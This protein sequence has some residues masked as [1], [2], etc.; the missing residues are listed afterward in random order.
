[1]C[2]SYQTG[3]RTAIGEDA[4]HCQTLGGDCGRYYRKAPEMQH[5]TFCHYLF[6]QTREQA[7]LQL[8]R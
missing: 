2:L 6:N 7:T 4:D 5:K 8:L 3:S 1:M